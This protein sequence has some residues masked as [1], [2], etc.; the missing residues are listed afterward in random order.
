MRFTKRNK[1]RSKTNPAAAASQV[2]TESS[3]KDQSESKSP[4]PNIKWSALD[5]LISVVFLI[6][7]LVGIYFGSAKLLNVLNER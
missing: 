7:V 1:N 6:V 2:E 3:Q 5:G 4:E